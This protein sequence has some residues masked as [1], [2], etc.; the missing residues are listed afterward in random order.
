ME[1]QFDPLHKG[2]HILTDTCATIKGWGE[3][4]IILIRINC[5]KFEFSDGIF[6]SDFFDKD[7]KTV[8]MKNTCVL[9]I[10][11]IWK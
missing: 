5:A 7:M 2:K 6:S 4:S 8:H 11:L 9:A 10:Y 1:N 3:K